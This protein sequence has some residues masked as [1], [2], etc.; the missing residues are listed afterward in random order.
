[1]INKNGLQPQ[2]KKGYLG[3]F[4]LQL[5][6]R[7]LCNHGTFQKLSLGA[8]E[9]DPDQAI[10]HL[11]KQKDAKCEVCSIKIT[12]IQGI[13]EKRSGS[14]TV[15]GHLL[16]TKCV[17]K[18][19][20]ALRAVPGKDGCFQCS[21]CAVT[22]FG[23]FIVDDKESS[24]SSKGGSQHLSAWQYFDKDGCSTKISAVVADIEHYKTEGKR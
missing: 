23:N 6:L 17:P 10:A 4:Q 18:L 24:K 14:F 13:E 12:G 1:L 20:S 9:F 22:I 8:D 5:Q 7:R 11:K 16:C 2:N 15:C 19:K 21:L 3:V